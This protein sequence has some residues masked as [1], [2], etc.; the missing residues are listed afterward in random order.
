MIIE[1]TKNFVMNFCSR[2]YGRKRKPK[3][4]RIIEEIKN[5]E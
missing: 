2:I 3:T 5:N 4:K 1:K